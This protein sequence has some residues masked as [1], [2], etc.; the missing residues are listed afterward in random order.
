MWGI[1]DR[2][3]I[4]VGRRF[5]TWL[6]LVWLGFHLALGLSACNPQPSAQ[7]GMS[8]SQSS[9]QTQTEP[10]SPLASVEAVPEP[11]LPDWIEEI[12]PQKQAQPLSQIRIR[13]KEP[14][15]PL[16]A[17]ESDN[18][19]V[20]LD[21]FELQPKFPGQFRILTPRM[22][23][24][25]SDRALPVASRFQVRLKAGLKDLSN[26]Q[27]SEDLVWSFET[28]AIEISDL[29]ADQEYQ[30]PF[31]LSPA[32]GFVA[33][34]ELDLDSLKEH[35]VLR[36]GD[37]VVTLKP[38]LEKSEESFRSSAIAFDPSQ[39]P[40]RY[41]LEPSKKLEKSTAYS[42][43]LTPGL[44]P[45]VGNLAL[46]KAIASTITT[47]APLQFKKID[48]FG[49]PDGGGT[50][51]RFVKGQ[52]QLT[53]NNPLDRDSVLANIKLTPEPN[54]SV[55]ALRI[56]DES[57]TVDLNPWALEPGTTYQVELGTG[58]QDIFGQT[59][60]QAQTLTYETGDVAA[61]LWAPGDLNIFPAGQE[62]AL[63]VSAVNLPEAKFQQTVKVLQP[64][65][66]AGE[67]L[68]YIA[69][70]VE[71]LL[72]PVGQWNAVTVK[73]PQPNQPAEMALNLKDILKKPTGLVAYG[74]TGKTNSYQ[75]DGKTKQRSPEFYGMVQL[76]RLGVFAQ[77]F[78][79][80]GWVRAHHLQDGSPVA[81]APVEIYANA[82]GPCATGKTDAQGTFQ[83]QGGA[84]QSCYAAGRASDAYEQ[85]GP[86]LL[87]VVREADDW[88]F[89][90]TDA[91]S[92]SYGY[93]VSPQW[94]SG[95]VES[96]GTIFSDRQLYQPGET[97]DF[98]GV[99]YYL[100]DGKLQADAN[101]TYVVSIQ[102]PEGQ[103]QAL[104]QKTT[105][106]LGTFS[107]DLPLEDSQALGFYQ[108]KAKRN[109]GD[110]PELAGEFRVAEFKPLNFKVDLQLSKPF[111]TAGSEITANAESQYLFG[112]P[113]ADA[114]IQ[115]FVT[116]RP[117]EDFAPK[118]WEAFQFGRQWLW[119]E[120]A[121][122]VESEVLQE[123]GTLNGQGQG[124]QAI[125]I[126]QDLP[127]PMTY[128]VDADVTDVANLSVGSSQTLTALPSDRLIGLRSNS[129]ADAGQAFSVDVIVTDPE[130]QAIS[131]QAVELQ[132]EQREFSYI[133][134]VVAG[135]ERD[136]N[137]VT[138]KPVAQAT[139]RSGEQPQP[140]QFTAPE[141][142]AYRIRANLVGSSSDATATERSLWATGTGSFFWGRRDQAKL[143]LQL[144]RETYKPG[145]TATVLIQSPFE[146]GELFLSVVRDRPLYQT[147]VPV[148][149]SAPQ[150]QFTVTPEMLPNAAVEAVLVRKGKPLADLAEN[151]VNQLEDLVQIGFQ[152]FTLDLAS[153][154]LQVAVQPQNKTLEPGTDQ[155]VAFTV[156][157]AQNQ[158]VQ[159]QM[160]VMVVNEAVLQLTGYRP[161]DLVKTLYAEQPIT[162]RFNDNR[163]DVILQTPA[164][165]LEKGWGYGGG[166]ST[167]S[168]NTRARRDFRP[169]AYY[170][171]AVQTDAKGQAQIQF[172][173]PDDL[174]TWRVM[175]VGLAQTAQSGNAPYAAGNG[176]E[177]FMTQR[178]LLANP[179]LPQ[180]ARPGDR[181]NLGLTLTNS[182][183]K[184]GTVAVSSQLGEG[185]KFT[186][187]GGQAEEGQTTE[188]RQKVGD[189]KTEALRFP[190]VVEASGDTK[191]AFEAQLNQHIDAFELPLSVRSLDLT[192]QTIETGTTQNTVTIPLQIN[193][194]QVIPNA[195]GLEVSLA[196][197]LIPE[198]NAA[199][200]AV[201]NEEN[202]EFLEP[203]ASQLATAASL[204]NL[205]T[206][207]YAPRKSQLQ[208]TAIAALEQLQTLQKP[209]G[210][211]ASWATAEQSDPG[212]TPYAAEAIAQAQQAQIPVNSTLLASLRR[213]LDKL[214]SDP[215]QYSYCD[216]PLC[217][218]SLRLGALNALAELGD[219]REDY[220]SQIYQERNDLS[221]VNQLQLA[222]HL[223]RL[224]NWQSQAQALLTE[225]DSVLYDSGRNARLNLPPRW[226]WL[227]SPTVEQA[228]ALRL[229]VQRDLPVERVDRLL[230]SLLSLRN[231]EGTWGNRY[232]N[233]QALLA[234][235]TV[236]KA[237]PVNAQ[238][239]ATATLGNQAIATAPLS[240]TQPSQI[241]TVAMANLLNG[242]QE[243]VLSKSGSGTLHY[244]AAYRYRP[245]NALPGRFGGLRVTREVKPV[246][247]GQKGSEAIARHGLSAVEKPL[248]VRAGQVFD[249]GI[250]VIA[251]HP[252]DHLV[253]TD[254]L[255]AGFEAVDNS[256]QTST[257][258]FEAEDDSW[259][260]S[261]QTI[262]QDRVVAYGEQLEAGIYSLH[263]LV[264]S[265]TPGEYRWPGAQAQL[266]YAPE[267]FGRSGE[268][269]LEVE[270]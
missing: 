30:P 92:G 53:F 55:P 58:I 186:K 125:A 169:L 204:L 202:L 179:A 128:R 225:F 201:L 82:S 78:P 248:Q 13:F 172:K 205:G 175:A 124:Q 57:Q 252:V 171:G 67:S 196:S 119:P 59:L 267:E 116:R 170:N 41:R 132:L 37:Q 75:E 239:T 10:L 16:E 28:P 56:Y 36:V 81:N 236:A 208:K 227:D 210:G 60:E 174:T 130:G 23:G 17:L 217:K 93:G 254:P 66:I 84:L 24:F 136:R 20:I 34:T 85:E 261:Y 257:P 141:A 195:G 32:L 240:P 181:L 122:E 263:Y 109:G 29:S 180:F 191:I 182:T 193:K 42:L 154:Y 46:E 216:D 25:Q 199:A 70:T 26:H 203:T 62:I 146:A 51:G 38:S 255:P 8:V 200:D 68:D 173:L 95:Q 229:Y 6:V 270:G 158:P 131:G 262:Y 231:P 250:E 256:F 222:R 187:G 104:G 108:I 31:S 126:A 139:V 105:T 160:A 112:A 134:Q 18:Q 39:K 35:A 161:P 90:A 149:G 163:L 44:R 127:Y 47:Y 143:E 269:V 12:S 147:I 110:Y 76:T 101:A 113:L 184:G 129:V 220:V 27:L 138:Y 123:Q 9:G 258:Y 4:A 103:S 106:K 114:Q 87:A 166:F 65:D 40:W 233:A 96:R 244:L 198:M 238:F 246:Q 235:A 150:V 188:A 19:Q 167:G 165:P 115:Y 223:L 80:L 242:N 94:N 249:I 63:N 102:G 88:A 164:S 5:A 49:Q 228:Q 86:K 168:G 89:A 21:Q 189:G 73:N 264:R 144:D 145:D 265:V 212:V 3:V 135:S 243:L 190:V 120:K 226:G 98:T 234:L 48:Y 117:A 247:G 259:Q 209:D 69:G 206:G 215:G 77:W 54:A 22:V 52:A 237:E 151:E 159:G 183:G 100:K 221:L 7:P 91:Y 176:E 61:D 148:Q 218:A 211:F 156:T 245:Q 11:T 83:L 155:T 97:A 45:A 194:D 153:Q 162:T 253:I 50:Y 2:E 74:V 72:P 260:L 219:V 266:Q 192:E 107:V 197:T 232:N 79:T 241:Q 137:Q 157:N 121:P 43:E 251:D 14:L 111:A 71:S 268:A 207:I 177:T 15:I 214:L 213:Y 99:A 152:S 140:V 33:N 185:L 142:G 133:R 230:R 1:L 118:G 224:P 64:Q 178:P